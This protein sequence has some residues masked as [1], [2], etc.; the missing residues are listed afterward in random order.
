MDMKCRILTLAVLVL[1][2]LHSFAA[3]EE[4]MPVREINGKSYYEYRI[5]IVT[6][7]L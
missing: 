6:K 2:S 7:L 4:N 3:E 5:P 1:L